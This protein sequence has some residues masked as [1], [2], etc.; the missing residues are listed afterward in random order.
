[1]LAIKGSG[2]GYKTKPSKSGSGEEK[3]VLRKKKRFSTEPLF[4]VRKKMV[5][6][7]TF[8]SCA[9]P[10]LGGSGLWYKIEPFTAGKGSAELLLY[11]SE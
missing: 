3:M 10:F 1:M 6:Y 5:L 9:E 7:K 2:L 4:F 11:F 8:F